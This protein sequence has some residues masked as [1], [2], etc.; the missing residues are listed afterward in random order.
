MPPVTSYTRQITTTQA[1][2]LREVLTGKGFQFAE[3]Q[4]CIFAASGQNV[5][6]AVYEKGPK[7]LIQ[8]KGTPA[9]IEFVLEPEIIGVAE[10]GYEEVLNP[11]MF[12]PHIGVDESGKGDFFGPLVIS[13]VYVD[14][15]VARKLRDLG[16]MDSKRIGSDARIGTLAGQMRAV[17]GLVHETIVMGPA[18]YNELYATFGNLNKLLAWG[19]ARIIENILER[20][21]GCPRALSDQFANPKVLQAA[22]QVRGKSILLEQRTKAES[23]PA[24]AAASIFAREGFVRWLDQNSAKLGLPLPKGVSPFVKASAVDFIRRHSPELLP[25]V[26]KMHFKTAQEVLSLAK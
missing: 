13:G 10:M 20:V 6:V 12:S 1:A 11:D 16:V 7:V 5:S 19:H 25:T 24:V 23:D 3:K 8:G 15:E 2:R 4:Y 9:F 26:A 17:H 14:G 21:P 18:R 22:L